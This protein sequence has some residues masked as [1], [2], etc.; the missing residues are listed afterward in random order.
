MAFALGSRAQSL[1]YRLEYFDEIGSTNTEAMARIQAGETG[2]LWLVTT[3]QTAG[4]GRRN[5][6]WVAPRGNLAA[7]ITEVIAVAPAQA[8]TLGFAAGVAVAE[9]LQ[10]LG[11]TTELK[12][13]NDVLLKGAKL[14]GISVQAENAGEGRLAM[15]VGIGINV[16]AAPEGLP[17][18]V[19][20]LAAA[21]SRITAETL[22]A[23]LSD[24]WAD[25]RSLWDQG[26]GMPALRKRW[27]A[28]AVG[29]GQ[30]VAVQIGER[31]VTGTFETLDESGHLMVITE[32]GQRMPIAS[33]EVFFGEATTR[34]GAA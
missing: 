2:P 26:R 10:S 15:I 6:P 33:G 5:R 31:R 27:L 25:T 20:S 14:C 34:T 19:A 8:A 21:G 17:H 30:P 9:S 3:L 16:V 11:V 12:W 29:V 7:T 28:H 18:P 23:T 24:H 13:P 32:N 4:S 1:G 22:F